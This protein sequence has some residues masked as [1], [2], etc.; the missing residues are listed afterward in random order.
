MTIPSLPAYSRA[1][2][3]N[4][5]FAFEINQR[6]SEHNWPI[7][8]NAV[9]TR[10]VYTESSASGL[11]SIFHAIPGVPI[12]YQRF[13]CLFFGVHPRLDRVLY[14]FRLYPMSRLSMA[15]GGQYIDALCHP[16][17]DDDHPKMKALRDADDKW[18]ERL[19]N[20]SLRLLRESPA[21]NV[22]QMAP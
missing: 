21:Q 6:F 5:F 14:S 16:A 9:H 19:W 3:C 17:L 13:W 8:A 18:A 15:K 11:G 7:I 20:V 12:L 4:C 22:V 10:G 1:K 2:L